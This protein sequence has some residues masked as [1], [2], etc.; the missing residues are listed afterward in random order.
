[1]YGSPGIGG[2]FID[3]LPSEMT[4]RETRSGRVLGAII[5]LF[6]W[7]LGRTDWQQKNVWNLLVAVHSVNV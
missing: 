1:M 3:L 5:Y 6:A 4:V 7:M 2:P